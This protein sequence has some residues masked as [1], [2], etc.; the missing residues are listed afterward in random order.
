MDDK[1]CT[2]DTETYLGSLIDPKSLKVVPPVPTGYP[3]SLVEI[4]MTGFFQSSPQRSNYIVL[5]SQNAYC[6]R[7]VKHGAYATTHFPVL[8]VRGHTITMSS[9]TSIAVPVS[10]VEQVKMGLTPYFA[11]TAS[12]RFEPELING[13]VFGGWMQAIS[14]TTS[15]TTTALTGT[16]AGG[17]LSDVRRVLTGMSEAQLK[18]ETIVRKDGVG[19]IPVTDGLIALVGTDFPPVPTSLSLNRSQETGSNRIFNLAD[20]I[21][22][23]SSSSFAAG[24]I[25][26]L[27]TGFLSSLDSAPLSF[28]QPDTCQHKPLHHCL[29]KILKC[30]YSAQPTYLP[31]TSLLKTL[32]QMTLLFLFTYICNP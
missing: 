8:T 28:Y 25:A 14:N 27:S 24:T 22:G 29:Y 16:M 6:K 31:S 32:W 5:L 11:Q 20:G 10:S 17:V 13:I 19:T 7:F 21:G 30:H 1:E 18:S 26:F 9:F 2:V 15:I 3:L 12:A 23:T 4:A